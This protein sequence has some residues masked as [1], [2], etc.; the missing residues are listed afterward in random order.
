M[1]LKYKQRTVSVENVR[2][3]ELEL[4]RLHPVPDDF[5][6][7]VDSWASTRENKN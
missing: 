7:T 3:L 1:V 2:L 4:I 5:T 6:R